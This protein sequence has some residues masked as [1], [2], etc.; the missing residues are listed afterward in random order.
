MTSRA[1]KNF[2]KRLTQLVTDA[3]VSKAHECDV[4]GA[5]D[6]ETLEAAKS[7]EEMAFHAGKNHIF[8]F[9]LM[10]I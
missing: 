1:P 3:I 7:L 8:E 2:W 4:F 5:L 6:P 9:I 10:N